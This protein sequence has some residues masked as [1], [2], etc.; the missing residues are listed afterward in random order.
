MQFA[1]PVLPNQIKHRKYKMKLRALADR[2]IV[3]RLVQTTTTASG[4]VLPG[5]SNEKP[6]QGEVVGFGTGVEFTNGTTRPLV[7]KMGD[8]VL[9]SYRSGQEVKVAGE[10]YLILKESEIFAIIENS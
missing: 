6:D 4:I 10:N 9:F 5:E 3:K 7:V 1:L 2:V 8:T